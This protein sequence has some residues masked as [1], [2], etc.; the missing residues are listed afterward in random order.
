MVPVT[1]LL[2]VSESLTSRPQDRSTAVGRDDLSDL[3]YGLIW[4]RMLYWTSPERTPYTY[5][6]L[7][8]YY[9]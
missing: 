1:C 5:D 4:P 2:D 8:H 3:P 9:Y 7:E 6:T